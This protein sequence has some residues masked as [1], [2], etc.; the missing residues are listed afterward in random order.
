MGCRDEQWKCPMRGIILSL[1]Q[2]CE[3]DWVLRANPYIPQLTAFWLGNGSMLSWS[4]QMSPV[5]SSCVLKRDSKRDSRIC[6]WYLKNGEAITVILTETSRIE[7][8]LQGLSKLTFES[9]ENGK[10]CHI[11]ERDQPFLVS[12]KNTHYQGRFWDI[13]NRTGGWKGLCIHHSSG[14]WSRRHSQGQQRCLALSG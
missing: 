9:V 1:P 13:K 8:W 7:I 2:D 3:G 14:I 4:M 6:C 12:Q 10:V 11:V 5:L